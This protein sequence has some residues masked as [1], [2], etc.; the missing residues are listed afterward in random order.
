[1]DVSSILTS[2]KTQSSKEQDANLF[3]NM[4]D[5]ASKAALYT[6]SAW[7]YQIPKFFQLKLSLG[8]LAWVPNLCVSAKCSGLYKY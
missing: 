7:F 3:V 8:C 2:D 5:A 1:M 6:N 4:I